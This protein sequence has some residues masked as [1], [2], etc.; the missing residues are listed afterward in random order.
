MLST[1]IRNWRRLRRLML[2]PYLLLWPTRILLHLFRH[3][4]LILRDHGHWRL[5]PLLL[6]D[7]VFLHKHRIRCHINFHIIIIIPLRL[8]PSIHLYNI[9]YQIR[10]ISHLQIVFLVRIH[11]L[12]LL[13][14]KYV[15]L[16]FFLCHVFCLP[17]GLGRHTLLLFI[18]SWILVCITVRMNFFDLISAWALYVR[19]ACWERR[20]F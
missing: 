3:L 14:L 5:G 13:I 19:V 4:R 11:H 12:H 8:S 17:V 16:N 18:S 6:Y 7:R 2:T 9:L 10:I 20:F 1:T 15:F